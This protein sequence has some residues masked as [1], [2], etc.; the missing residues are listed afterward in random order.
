MSPHWMQYE[1]FSRKSQTSFSPVRGRGQDSL[2]QQSS[3]YRPQ[4]AQRPRLSRPSQARPLAQGVPV[5]QHAWFIAP[6][7]GAQAPF[8]HS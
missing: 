2:A 3:V 6:Q 5:M 8:L 1:G 4:G 7:M